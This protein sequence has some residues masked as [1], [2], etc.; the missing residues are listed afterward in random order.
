VPMGVFSF[1]EGGSGLD[2][3]AGTSVA[4]L[5]TGRTFGEG[6]MERPRRG[7]RE[8]EFVLEPGIGGRRRGAGEEDMVEGGEVTLVGSLE[9]TM[10][11]C[12][13]FRPM[14]PVV[15]GLIEEVDGQPLATMG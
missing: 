12:V 4:P 11:N 7:V 6:G 8:A 5:V 1:S 15:S 3:R 13:G 2:S 9:A 10:G 14:Q